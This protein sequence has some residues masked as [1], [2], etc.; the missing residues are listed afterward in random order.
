MN[1]P[2]IPL[3]L[4]QK[5]FTIIL[6]ISLGPR[7]S[8]QT[9]IPL[10]ITT[11]STNPILSSLTDFVSFVI[12]GPTFLYDVI[13]HRRR[14]VEMDVIL[15]DELPTIVGR[16]LLAVLLCG[17]IGIEREVNQHPAGFRTHLLV[18]VGSCL[19][20]ILSL[21]GFEP[22]LKD[23]HIQFDPARIPS[24]VISGIGFLGAGTILVKDSTVR[25]LT[26]AASIWVVAGLGLIIGAGLYSV[27]IITT[28]IILIILIT[29]NRFENIFLQRR[30]NEQKIEVSLSSRD[31]LVT[32]IQCIN[33]FEGNIMTITSE[34]SQ[35]NEI[36]IAFE[37]RAKNQS[38]LIKQLYSIEGV[39]NFIKL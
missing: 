3:F 30:K 15:H 9:S 37:S 4:L 5:I 36:K 10:L 2:Y 31:T 38:E 20:M 34:S 26:T 29:L 23:E 7:G 25:G 17:F 18:G 33:D 12:L 14:A 1:F 24:Y 11:K 21:Y 16:L 13:K 27:S 19:M 6:C 32:V 8:N 22:F 39:Q 35:R 28:V